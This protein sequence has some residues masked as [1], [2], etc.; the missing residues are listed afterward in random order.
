MHSRADTLGISA[1]VYMKQLLRAN[2]KVA[3]IDWQTDR[4]P[5]PPT[6]REVTIKNYTTVQ[7]AAL[8][9]VMRKQLLLAERKKKLMATKRVRKPRAKEATK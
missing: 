7:I 8:E 9:R 4:E 2:L 6:P 1:C 5:I 3:G